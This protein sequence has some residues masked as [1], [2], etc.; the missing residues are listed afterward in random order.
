MPH[1]MNVI[2]VLLVA[3][4][5]FAPPS[6]GQDAGPAASNSFGF[7]LG[8]APGAGDWNRVRFAPEVALLSS[9]VT[10]NAD[11]SFALSDRLSLVIDGGYAQLDGGDWEAYAAQQGDEVR[12]TASYATIAVLLRS[13]LRADRPD[14]LWIECGPAALFPD[15]EERFNGTVY[16][17]DFFS[18]AKV[19]GQGAFGYERML[20]ERVSATLQAGALL[21]PSGV[22]YADGAEFTMIIFPITAGVRVYY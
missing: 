19:G 16:R 10:F 20:G 21:F 7:R 9:G 8:Y 17:Y 13:F 12:V 14:F 2:C 6:N 1:A 4:A 5:F 11:L 18:S 3:L 22:S 15:G